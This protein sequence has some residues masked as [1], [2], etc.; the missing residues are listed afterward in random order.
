MILPID[1]FSI[2]W[3]DGTSKD[4]TYFWAIIQ[5]NKFL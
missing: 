4:G 2:L 3:Y 5:Q 1:H